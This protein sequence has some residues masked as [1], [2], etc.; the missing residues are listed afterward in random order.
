MRNLIRVLVIGFAAVI[1]LLAAAATTG[2][3]NARLI[4][5]SAKSLVQ[6]QLVIVQLLDEMQREQNVLNAAFYRLSTRQS[7]VDRQ[8]VLADLDQTDQE[9]TKMVAA[10][11]GGDDEADWNDLERAILDFSQEARTLLTGQ[12]VPAYSSR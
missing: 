12:D 9:I 2:A 11:Q 6:N 10:A 5:A 4:A 7:D 1:A 8:D 3:Y